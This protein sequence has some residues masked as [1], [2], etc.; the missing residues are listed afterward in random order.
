M[1]R[2]S[3]RGEVVRSPRSRGK[4]GGKHVH[5]RMDSAGQQNIQG[6]CA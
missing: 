2:V 6:K 4:S 1:I 3:V 5:Y